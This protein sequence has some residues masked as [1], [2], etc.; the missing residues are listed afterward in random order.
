MSEWISVEVRLP[1]L[2]VVVDVYSRQPQCKS[3]QRI[4]GS[5]LE[6]SGEWST[7]HDGFFRSIPDVTHWMPLP[8]P[9]QD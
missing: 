3:G 1:E 5:W 6:G 9:P 4:T 7:I 2:D 8:N